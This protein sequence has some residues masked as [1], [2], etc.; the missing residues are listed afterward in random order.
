[1][2]ESARRADSEGDAMRPRRLPDFGDHMHPSHQTRLLLMMT[3]VSLFLVAQ[4]MSQSGALA[5]LP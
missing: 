4:L 1:M 5:A 2:P 3:M